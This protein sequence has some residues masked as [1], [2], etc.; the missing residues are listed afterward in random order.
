LVSGIVLDGPFDLAVGEVVEPLEEEGPQV[1]TQLEF[2][3]KPPFALGS[4]TLKVLKNYV[5]KALPGDD[6]GQLEQRMGG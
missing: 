6:M 3:A 4:G 5:D 2:S 1:D